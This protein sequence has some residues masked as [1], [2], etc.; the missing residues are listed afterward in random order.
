MTLAIILVLAAALALFLILRVT[1][2]RGLQI[3]GDASLA[4]Q[5]QPI[6]I[7]AFRNLADPD[8][9]WFLR[10]NLSAEAFRAVQRQRLLAMAAYLRTVGRNA[11]ILIRISQSALHSSD[12]RTVE[13][14]RQLADQALF[15]RRNVIFALARIYVALP[16]P[17]A[18]LAADPLV[19]SY[20]RMSGSA[21][22]LGRLQNPAAPVRIS[23]S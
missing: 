23:A 10:C 6:D 1:L 20:E 22:L 13:A 17:T 8:E 21:M 12:A 16:W 5:I 19:E 15:L 11:D 7:E 18:G 3:S 9:S 2:S 4:G 14:A